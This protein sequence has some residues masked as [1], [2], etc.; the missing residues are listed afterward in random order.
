VLHIGIVAPEQI[1]VPPVVSGSVEICISMI[2]SQLAKKHQVTIISRRHSKYPNL[3]RHGNLTHIRVPGGKS[4][5]SYIREVMNVLH[6]HRFDLIE[7]NNRPRYAKLIKDRFPS[8]PV[9]LVLHSL[10]FVTPPHLPLATANSF[11]S[12]PDLIV[13][14]SASLRHELSQ[15]F[16]AYVNKIETVPLGVDTS[17]FR[18]PSPAEKRK[19]RIKYGVAKG[20]NVLFVG[21]LV[22]RKGIGVLIRAMR[23]LRRAVP[24]ARLI[25]AGGSP[26]KA[27]IQRMKRL[28]NTLH[29][30]AKFLGFVPHHELHKA[31]WLGDCFIC[32]SQLHEAFGLVNVEAM[33]SGV[34]VIASRI[35]GI[36][37]IIRHE[38]TGL[39]VDR[40]QD[41][42]AFA[43]SMKRL[44]AQPAFA[45]QLSANARGTVVQQFGWNR[46]AARFE[47][48]YTA[49][50]A[51]KP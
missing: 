23:Q 33:A 26:H 17:T 51:M 16:P 25:V 6:N 41:A 20:Y 34:P 9:A 7:V 37:E 45:S 4:G 10:T 11:L 19:L 32:P 40:F 43:G 24:D 1:P 49:A 47:D 14:N 12:K 5:A 22:P 21:R 13:A 29:V 38:Q 46:T 39:L 2:A 3:S 42:S 31:Y 28:A 18:L 8:T 48:I 15:R 50:N 35:G 44:A 27:Y 30:P 36:Q